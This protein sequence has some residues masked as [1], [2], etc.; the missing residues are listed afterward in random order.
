MAALGSHVF[1]SSAST[2]VSSYTLRHHAEQMRQRILH[3]TYDMIRNRFYVDDGSG[4]ADIPEEMLQL[5]DDLIAAMAEGGFELAKFKSNL[6]NFMDG[7]CAGEVKIGA[8]HDDDETTK[9]LGVSWIPSKDIFTF[10]FDPEIATRSVTT[11]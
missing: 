9:V 1:G 11:P 5:V 3:A 2:I 6:P 10:N 4:G 8:N 7:D